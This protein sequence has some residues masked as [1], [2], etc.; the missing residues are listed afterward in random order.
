MRI[1]LSQLLGAA[2]LVLLHGVAQGACPAGTFPEGAQ[3]CSSCTPGRAAGSLAFPTL[4]H[5]GVLEGEIITTNVNVENNSLLPAIE[6]QHLLFSG[7]NTVLLNK[8]P[9]GGI[10]RGYDAEGEQSINVRVRAKSL[11]STDSMVDVGDTSQIVMSSILMGG[12]AYSTYEKGINPSAWF[13][14][15]KHALSTVQNVIDGVGIYRIKAQADPQRC[16]D[17]YGAEVTCGSLDDIQ[18]KPWP[19]LTFFTAQIDNSNDKISASMYEFYLKRRNDGDQDSPKTL[20]LP[21]QSILSDTQWG[22]DVYR[23]GE[24]AL[25]VCFDPTPN[26]LSLTLA[27]NLNIGFHHARHFLV[28]DFFQTDRWV[29]LLI[30]RDFTGRV[31]IFKD[32]DL[33]ASVDSE[34][35]LSPNLYHPPPTYTKACGHCTFAVSD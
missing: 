32:R 12:A 16:F 34:D 35:C 2:I 13:C 4:R 22:I 15:L 23:I 26:V 11:P 30:S 9:N 10:A 28:R 25:G 20:K 19:G 33:M 18:E 14:Y 29:D 7:N 17:S 3:Q 1:H 31:K 6:D 5:I 24:S 27:S 8:A 21:V